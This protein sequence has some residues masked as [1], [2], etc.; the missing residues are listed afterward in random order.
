MSFT[1]TRGRRPLRTVDTSVSR[2]G[3]LYS[4]HLSIA[5]LANNIPGRNCFWDSI[6]LELYRVHELLT[7]IL[8]TPDAHWSS[9]ARI[10]DNL[11]GTELLTGWLTML[12]G[13]NWPLLWDCSVAGSSFTHFATTWALT[14]E[15]LRCK[16]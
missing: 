2:Q 10:T 13:Q 4:I 16:R 3:C 5:E 6:V 12:E 9:R 7:V 15:Y 11:V 1:T 8:R 14:L